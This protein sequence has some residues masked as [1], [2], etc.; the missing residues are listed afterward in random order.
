MNP[1]VPVILGLMSVIIWIANRLYKCQENKLKV[2]RYEFLETNPGIIQGTITKQG[3]EFVIDE[4]MWNFYREQVKEA[5]RLV[6]EAPSYQDALRHMK[7]RS[8]AEKR[9]DQIERR[10]PNGSNR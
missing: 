10:M 3:M 8:S 4:A 6:T 9:I 2:E 1:A 7:L 5:N